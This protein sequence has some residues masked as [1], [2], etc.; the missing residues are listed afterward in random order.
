MIMS[1]FANMGS[2]SA[3]AS[4]EKEA[5]LEWENVSLDTLS[6]EMREKLVA[7]LDASKTFEDAMIA[8]AKKHK[9]IA[10][11][12]TMLFSYKFLTKGKVGCAEVTPKQATVKKVS[13]F[14]L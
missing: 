3:S 10:P 7:V 13:R 9:R 5:D 11:A 1:K 6:P 14:A 4:P 8:S 12:S 2:V